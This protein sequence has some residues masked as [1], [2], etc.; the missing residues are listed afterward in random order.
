MK[1]PILFIIFNRPSTTAEAFAAIRERRPEKLYIAADGPR[2]SKPDDKRLTTEA[3]A[4]VSQIDWDCVVKRNYQDE[5]LGCKMGVAG[6]ISW[7]F[8]HEPEGIIIEDDL[9]PAQGFFPFC[10]KMLEKY[11]HDSRVMMITGTNHLSDPDA[12]APYFFSEHFT[13]WGWASWARAWKHYDVTMAQWNEPQNRR[14]FHYRFQDS[15]IAD[16]FI[17]TFGLIEDGMDTWDIQWVLACFL[18]TG[19]CVTPTVNLVSNIGL[20]GTHSVSETTSHYLPVFALDLEK[21]DKV[22]PA[23]HVNPAYDNALHA[24]KSKP[25]LQHRR[26]IKRARR[27]GLYTMLK[28]LYHMARKVN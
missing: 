24:L 19:L 1:T 4:V 23:V 14:F 13:I 6:A 26:W 16:H 21:L 11:R 18:A 5:N 25:A 28:T 27:L 17:S 22:A 9:V 10:E 3:R 20:V 12:E 8:D 15:Y 2:A 7:F